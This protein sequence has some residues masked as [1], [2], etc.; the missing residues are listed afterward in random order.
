MKATHITSTLGVALLAFIAYGFVTDYLGY[1]LAPKATAES[2][3]PAS[4]VETISFLTFN[5]D[6]FFYTP[7]T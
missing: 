5:L 3:I 7:N 4:A 6:I 2:A 1:E